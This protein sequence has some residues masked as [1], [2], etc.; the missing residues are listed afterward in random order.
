MVWEVNQR[1]GHPIVSGTHADIG[2][3]EGGQV[4]RY[5]AVEWCR[6]LIRSGFVQETVAQAPDQLGHLLGHRLLDGWTQHWVTSPQQEWEVLRLETLQGLAEAELQ[7]GNAHKALVLADG[8]IRSDPL[9]EGAWYTLLRALRATRNQATARQRFTELVARMEEDLGIRPMFTW[10][11][12]DFHAN[13]V[14]G[15]TIGMSRAR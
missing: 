12:L 9:R 3:C 6:T 14:L 11:D 1:A 2:I 15:S 4:D 7:R 8:A 10:D 13:S 5:T